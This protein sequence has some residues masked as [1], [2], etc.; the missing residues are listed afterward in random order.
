MRTEARFGCQRRMHGRAL[1][2]DEVDGAVVDGGR[3]RVVLHPRTPAQI[4][5]D[6][7]GHSHVMYAPPSR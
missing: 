2:A 7:D 6:D 4:P 1:E 3:Q 5:E